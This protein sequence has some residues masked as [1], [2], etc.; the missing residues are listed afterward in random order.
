MGLLTAIAKGAYDI[1]VGVLSTVSRSVSFLRSTVYRVRGAVYRG[2]GE[3]LTFPETEVLIGIARDGMDAAGAIIG[4]QAAPP[5]PKVQLGQTFFALGGTTGPA[6][7]AAKVV[8]EIEFADGRKDRF[9]LFFS[10]DRVPTI[11]QIER[12][13]QEDWDI[14]GSDTPGLAGTPSA[15]PVSFRVIPVYLV[16]NAE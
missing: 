2:V 5:P 6:N 10:A 13:I 9:P 8:F 7:L 11:E 1:A 4:N 12:M 14:L 16:M 15:P 3:L